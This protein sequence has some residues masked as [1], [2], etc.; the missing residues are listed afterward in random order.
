MVCD[1]ENISP[2]MFHCI[3]RSAKSLTHK[4]QIKGKSGRALLKSKIVQVFHYIW[5][6]FL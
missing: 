4:P 3:P 2:A 6:F 5:E 1:D